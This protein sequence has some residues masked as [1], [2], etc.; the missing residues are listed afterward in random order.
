MPLRQLDLLLN[1]I[2]VVEQPFSRWRNT[3][4]GVDRERF[5][6]EGTEYILISVESGQQPVTPLAID[7]LVTRS[8][9][10]GMA[11][12][13]LDGEELGLQGRLTRGRT[14]A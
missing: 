12:Q 4:V 2:K 11:G 10:S 1:Q 5:A 9:T 13:L 7:N 14:R 6:I 3:S 8:E